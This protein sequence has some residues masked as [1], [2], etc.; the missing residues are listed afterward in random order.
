MH[1]PNTYI[2]LSKLDRAGLFKKVDEFRAALARVVV[3]PD[4][5]W[6]T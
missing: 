5:L 2:D 1:Y 4:P 3:D 6:E